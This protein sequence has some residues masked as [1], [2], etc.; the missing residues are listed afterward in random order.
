M[1]KR[2]RTD[3][4]RQVNAQNVISR[5]WVP[6]LSKVTWKLI[7]K[8]RKILQEWKRNLK[9]SKGF[10][11]LALSDYLI[12]ITNSVIGKKNCSVKCWKLRSYFA[13]A[14]EQLSAR[15][16]FGSFLFTQRAVS[17]STVKIFLNTFQNLKHAL[18]FWIHP[19]YLAIISSFMH[20]CYKFVLIYSFYMRST[21]FFTWTY[22]PLGGSACEY[23]WRM[24][25]HQQ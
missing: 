21:Y 17:P 11:I 19:T 13:S 18:Q 9:I 14:V 3:T 4:E 22:F 7:T 15:S 6:Q 25:D 2:L 23:S 8:S 1:P 24:A 10:S 5:L 16:I 12:W 20:V